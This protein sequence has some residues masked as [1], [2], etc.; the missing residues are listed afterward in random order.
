LLREPECSVEKESFFRHATHNLRVVRVSLFAW[1]LIWMVAAGDWLLSLVIERRECP[2]CGDDPSD[3]HRYCDDC[4]KS[5][6]G[7]D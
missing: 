3:G 4:Y 7:H 2:I 1:P 5:L 6:G